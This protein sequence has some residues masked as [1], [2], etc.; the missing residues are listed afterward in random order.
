MNDNEKQPSNGARE[1]LISIL[2]P[3]IHPDSADWMLGKLWECGFKVVPLDKD[4][5][6]SN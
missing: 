3:D 1:A 4:D 6:D 5:K 2:K